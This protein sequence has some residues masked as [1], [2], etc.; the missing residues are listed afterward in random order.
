[1]FGAQNLVVMYLPAFVAFGCP[2]EEAAI[3]LRK[4]SLTRSSLVAGF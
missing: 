4:L 2:E 3:F 1:M